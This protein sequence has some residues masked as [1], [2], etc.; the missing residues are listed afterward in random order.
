MRLRN[1]ATFAGYTVV[2]LLGSGVMGDVYLVEH[3]RLSRQR[4]LKVLP[5]QVSADAE[6]RQRFYR[7]ADLAA[8]FYHPHIVGVHDRGE[9]DGQLWIAMDYVEGADAAQLMKEHC[10]DGM[11][12]HDVYDIVTAV[13]DALD[14]AHQRPDSRTGRLR[15]PS[16]ANSRCRARSPWGPKWSARQPNSARGWTPKRPE[17]R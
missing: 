7:E 8:T 4:A 12:A 17:S 5:V 1:G 16:C 10:P 3:P 14:Y 2:R 11:P 13:A 9:F 6:F 15:A